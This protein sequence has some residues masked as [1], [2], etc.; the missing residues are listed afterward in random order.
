MRARDYLIKQ[1]AAEELSHGPVVEIGAARAERGGRDQ[2]PWRRCSGGWELQA[3]TRAC[4]QEET[5]SP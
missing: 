5:I 1:S 2:E 4:R 3:A